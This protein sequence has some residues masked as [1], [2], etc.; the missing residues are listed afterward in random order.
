MDQRLLDAEEA[1]QR[2]D[3][4]AAEQL[5]HDLLAEKPADLDAKAGLAQI[6]LVRRTSAIADPQAVLAEAADRPDDV[7]AQIRAADVELLYGQVDKTFARLVD[8]VRRTSGADRERVRTHL[9]GLFDLLAPDD[10]QV[11]K[12]RRD[13]TSALF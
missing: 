5:F 4:D 1:L 13:L 10:P 8:L 6:G 7:D 9:L 3:V 11:A 2:G 12:A